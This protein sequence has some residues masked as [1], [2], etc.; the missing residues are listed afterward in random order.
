MLKFN[1]KQKRKLDDFMEEQDC[2]AARKQGKPDGQPP[3]YGASGGAYTYM[4]TPTSLGTVVKVKN[5]VTG[6]EVDLTDYLEW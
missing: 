2:E 1:E 5:N 4:L 6:N 3:N